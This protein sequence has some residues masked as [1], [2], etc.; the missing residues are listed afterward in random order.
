MKKIGK[1]L[2]GGPGRMSQAMG[3]HVQLDQT[4]LTDNTIWIADEGLEIA[5]IVAD[6]RIGV[7]YAE[8][9]SLKPWRFTELGNSFVSVTPQKKNNR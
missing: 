7:D 8:E 5:G 2:T 3:F 4:D 9:D 1:V 6:Q